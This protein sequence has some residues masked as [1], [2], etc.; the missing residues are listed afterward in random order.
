MKRGTDEKG[1]PSYNAEDRDV[2]WGLV[3][4]GLGWTVC[5]ALGWIELDGS[6]GGNSQ[7]RILRTWTWRYGRV[8]MLAVG[9]W[10]WPPWVGRE[11]RVGEVMEIR[12]RLQDK[13]GGGMDQHVVFR[14]RVCCGCFALPMPAR[15]SE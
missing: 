7:E 13:K 6:G 12:R 3:L 9:D 11:Y 15:S 2:A 10:G 1:I 5:G 4:V 14:F 8:P